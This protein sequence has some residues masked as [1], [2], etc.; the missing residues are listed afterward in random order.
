MMNRVSWLTF[1]ALSL[2]G[3]F[4]AG[5]G[6]TLVPFTHETRV[7]HNL[8][9][10]DLKNLQYYVSHKITLRRELESGGRQVTGGHKLRLV[11]GKTIEEV[12]IEEKTPGIAVAVNDR[13]IAISFEPGSSLLFAAA[14]EPDSPPPSLGFAEPPP[15]PFPGS[16]HQDSVDRFTSFGGSYWLFTEGRARAAFQGTVFAAVDDSVQAHLMI[17]S[18]S[19]EEVVE[20]RKVLGGVRLPGN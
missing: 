9:K 14:S 8:S 18:E 16:S 2:F 11:S 4:T 5:C 12:V 7:Q 20:S 17:D 6:S 13:T 19:L 15:D 10:E 3:I 1:I